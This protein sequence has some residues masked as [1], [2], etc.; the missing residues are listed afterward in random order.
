MRTSQ[1]LLV[2]GAAMLPF[3]LGAQSLPAARATA[4][5]Q[6][7]GGAIAFRQSLRVGD[8]LPVDAPA[9]CINPPQPNV[10]SGQPGGGTMTLGDP[11]GSQGCHGFEA[12][13]AVHLQW[14]AYPGAVQYLV[15]ANSP[16]RNSLGYPTKCQGGLSM[17]PDL[18]VAVNATTTNWFNG[19]PNDF[20]C[21]YYVVAI[22][23]AN[24][25][26]VRADST[27]TTAVTLHGH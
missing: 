18:A 17:A 27:A 6:A 3:R 13:G 1:V 7:S 12:K 5:S 19:Q 10:P 24:E 16:D 20:H 14:G 26:L 23:R 9:R 11:P 15:V 25:L 4:V 8:A 22:T 2:T 21:T